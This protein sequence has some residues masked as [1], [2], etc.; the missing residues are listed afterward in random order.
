MLA[1]L[2]SILLCRQTVCVISHWVKH[3]ESLLTLVACIDVACDIAKRVS[4]VKSCSGRVGEHVENIEFLAFFVLCNFVGLVFDPFLLP[5]FLDVS[6]VVFHYIL[7]FL[8]FRFTIKYLFIQ[9]FRSSLP[10][11]AKV[12]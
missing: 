2:Y 11:L 9:L 7:Y 5:S 3:V 6:K 8:S 10:L 12:E 1:S 4:Y